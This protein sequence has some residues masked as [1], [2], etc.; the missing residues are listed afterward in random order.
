[1]S[2]SAANDPRPLPHWLAERLRRRL[3]LFAATHRPFLERVRRLAREQALQSLGLR[4]AHAEWQAVVAQ[5]REL[6]RR[7][8]QVRRALLALV[9]RVPLEQ[10]PLRPARRLPPEVRRALR[11]RRQLHEAELLSG[12]EIGRQ[13][14]GWRREQ[15][16]LPQTLAL[17]LAG[18]PLRNLWRQ[19]LALLG[20]EPTPLQQAVLTQPAGPEP[21][22]APRAPAGPG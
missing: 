21:A 11:Q 9:R 18:G 10:V 22:A 6:D 14:L 7:A 13:L 12:E 15:Q 1:M 2:P 19:L 5:R 20:E 4:E 8:R 3:A 17:A 16:E